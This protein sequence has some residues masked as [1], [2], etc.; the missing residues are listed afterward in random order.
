MD[1]AGAA[2]REV[3]WVGTSKQDLKTFPATAQDTIGFALYWAQRGERHAS[4]KPLRGFRGAG[5]LEV[6]EDA[7]GATYRAVY[8]VRMQTAVYV[9]HAFQKKSTR[10]IATPRREIALI[11]Q[12]LA[13]AERIEAERLAQRK[14][15]G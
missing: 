3:V 7:A 13:W 10:G 15:Q 6:V 8:T 5:V 2:V 9:L 1:K 4:A 11:E 14:E 12:R